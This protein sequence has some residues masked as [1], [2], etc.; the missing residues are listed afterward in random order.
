MYHCADH[1]EI[2]GS[3]V[4]DQNE[5]TDTSSHHKDGW[6]VDMLDG[7]QVD[8]WIG[9]GHSPATDAITTAVMIRPSWRFLSSGK[10]LAAVLG[11]IL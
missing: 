8:V 6:T 5:P 9:E 2:V 4:S 1:Q 7:S 10:V 3:R 11:S